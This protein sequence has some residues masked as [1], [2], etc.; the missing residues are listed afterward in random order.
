MLKRRQINILLRNKYEVV[1]KGIELK[2]LRKTFHANVCGTV[3]EKKN[4]DFGQQL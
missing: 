1:K 3:Y 2:K 4:S